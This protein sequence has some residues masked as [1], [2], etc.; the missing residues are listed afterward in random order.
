MLTRRED[1]LRKRVIRAREDAGMDRSEV[2]KGLSLEYQ[3]YSHYERGRFPFSIEHVFQL[4]R[5][6]GRPVEYFLGLDTGLSAD[7]GELLA[8]YRGVGGAEARAMLLRLVRSMA[9]GD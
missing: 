3:S 7:E 8:R 9:Q 2:A 1:E 4:A 6:L 5:I